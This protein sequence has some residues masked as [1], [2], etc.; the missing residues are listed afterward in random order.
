MLTYLRRILEALDHP[1]MINLILHY[2][3]GL[4]D[5]IA[6][7]ESGGKD[8][9]AAARKRK[10]MDLLSMIAESA[11]PDS[12]PMLFNLVDM[13]LSCLR[14]QNQQTIYVTLQLVSTILK[15]HHRYA[16]ITL[17][18]TEHI[19]KEPHRTI[20]AHKQEVEY[21]MSLAGVI[22]G[23]DHFDEIY[24]Y[25]LK[26]TMTRVESHPCSL[27]LVAPKISTNN[28]KLPAIPDSLPGAP[29]DVCEHTLRPEDPLLNTLIDILSTFFVNSVETNLSVTETLVDLAV[30]GYMAVEGWLARDPQKYIF[31]EDSD[32]PLSTNLTQ[33]LEHEDDD[34]I[35]LA[36][37]AAQ[38]AMLA[39]RRRPRWIP[40]TLPRLM[41]VLQELVDGVATYKETVPRFDDLLQQRRE[42]FQTADVVLSQPQL[43][44]KPTPKSHIN[45]PVFSQ[46]EESLLSGSP[47]R[48][49]GLEG[50]AQR[51]FSELSTPSRSGSPRG[52]VDLQQNYPHKTAE[53][54]ERMRDNTGMSGGYGISTPPI[55]P[56][57]LK[58]GPAQFPLNYDN[59]RHSG[60]NL[61]GLGISPG[62]TSSFVAGGGPPSTSGLT[63]D[64]WST[65]DAIESQKAAFA[66]VD[67]S[68]LNRKIGMPQP[69]R[70]PEPI[71]I[72]LERNISTSEIF[73]IP[74][75]N[76]TSAAPTAD[77]DGIEANAGAN[78]S[79]PVSVANTNATN[80]TV[81]ED[82][83]TEASDVTTAAT[84][85]IPLTSGGMEEKST[86]TGGLGQILDKNNDNEEWEEEKTA[87][88]SHV[89]TNVIILQSF[90]F[91]LASV[92]QVRAGLFDEVRFV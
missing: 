65:S 28:H 67:Q 59:P 52:R 34:P 6:E 32:S 60:Q 36:E 3:L 63:E 66:A 7:K 79:T 33:P 75:Q 68:I 25:I 53:M 58:Q 42:A 15:R 74:S 20:G 57:P 78:N 92:V 45:T 41:R 73:D 40:Q 21:F 17:L 72:Q 85:T 87:T 43:A 81:D 30:C 62:P 37:I 54:S 82:T 19:Y 10:S 56:I 70:K 84:T 35:D 55:R 18:R 11:R 23:L 24:E 5:A 31:D 64:V 90:L 44:R 51:I 2:L 46:S 49:S 38:R 22:G 77:Q 13:I 88:V 27:K 12:T 50:F 76:S 61:S 83:R 91:E 39:S 8:L 9:V 1:D 26:D 29:Q 86:A 80:T 14:S 16:V 47:A 71:P 89:V 69:P 48:P 4:P